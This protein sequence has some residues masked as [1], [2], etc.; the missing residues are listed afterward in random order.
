ML[1]R[2]RR[3]GAAEAGGAAAGQ[4]WQTWAPG[5][6][7]QHWLVCVLLGAGLVLRVLAQI[8]YRPPIIY[9]DTLKSSTASTRFRAVRV[10]L[11]AEDHP[12]RR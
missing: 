7:G 11:P 1:T 6:L 2:V 8:A 9:V 5:L 10:P 4:P 3:R 12:V